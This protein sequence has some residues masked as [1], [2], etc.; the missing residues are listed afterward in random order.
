MCVGQHPSGLVKAWVG[1]LDLYFSSHLNK[2]CNNKQRTAASK[3]AWQLTKQESD[4][5]FL[6]KW[7]LSCPEITRV[8]FRSSKYITT[9]TLTQATPWGANTVW[10]RRS[11]NETAP[12]TL[13]PLVVNEESGWP[14]ERKGGQNTE[15]VSIMEQL[16]AYK[17]V[18]PMIKIKIQKSM[19]NMALHNAVAVNSLVNEIYHLN[20]LWLCR[21]MTVL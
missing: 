6:A 10:S 9:K 14:S 12:A 1:R 13:L 3:N 15:L 5:A 18:L 4:W 17:A 20:V 16:Y 2:S 7:H 19:T 8:N 21:I 11:W